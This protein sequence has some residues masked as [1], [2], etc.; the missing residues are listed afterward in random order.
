VAGNSDCSTAS[1]RSVGL[2]LSRPGSF[3]YALLGARGGRSASLASA[4]GLIETWNQ[5]Q[6][7]PDNLMAAAAY[8]IADSDRSVSWTVGNCYNSATAMIAVERLTSN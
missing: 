4:T 2:S 1:L 8:V 7:T 3:V 6:A 5:R